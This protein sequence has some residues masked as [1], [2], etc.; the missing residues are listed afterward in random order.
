M[1][2]NT[3]ADIKPRGCFYEKLA[4]IYQRGKSCALQISSLS[5]FG[6]RFFGSAFI[7]ITKTVGDKLFG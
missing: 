6:K 7:G 3:P 2:C 5:L 4:G 1:I